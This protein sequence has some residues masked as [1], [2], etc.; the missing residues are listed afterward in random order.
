M[1]KGNIAAYAARTTNW[2]TH[3][4]TAQ[5]NKRWQAQTEAQGSWWWWW[6]WWW[7]WPFIRCSSVSMHSMLVVLADRHLEFGWKKMSSELIRHSFWVTGWLSW[8]SVG[9]EIQIS[10]VQTPL[11]SR[12]QKNFESL[13]YIIFT[14]KKFSGNDRHQPH[15]SISVPRK[16]APPTPVI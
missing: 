8:Y 4:L 13:F 9:F 1:H 10:E 5:T 3:L 15:I 11:E 12:A 2:S 6:W 14:P 16:S 7:W